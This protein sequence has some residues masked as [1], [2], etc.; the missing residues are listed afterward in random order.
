MPKTYIISSSDNEKVLQKTQEV[1]GCDN[2]L[3]LNYVKD[4]LCLDEKEEIK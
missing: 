1:F 3:I 4:Y 2:Y